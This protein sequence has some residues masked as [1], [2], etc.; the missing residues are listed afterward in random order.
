MQQA[1][2]NKTKAEQDEKEA[3]QDDDEEEETVRRVPR[4][5]NRKT[6]SISIAELKRMQQA[7]KT[8]GKLNKT[9]T[10][11]LAEEAVEEP[12]ATKPV[13]KQLLLSGLSDEEAMGNSKRLEM[14]GKKTKSELS[15]ITARRKHME[16]LLESMQS[17]MS[18]MKNVLGNSTKR[19]QAMGRR[20]VQQERETMRVKESMKQHMKNT[21]QS[22]NEKVRALEEK[23][24]AEKAKEADEREISQYGRLKEERLP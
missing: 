24:A 2:R 18:L 13:T 7:A 16:H 10:L 1:A 4:K 9:K 8:E 14:K 23:L 20:L 17:H 11:A 12:K 3:E 15:K 6:G 22:M 5:P 19:L 21:E